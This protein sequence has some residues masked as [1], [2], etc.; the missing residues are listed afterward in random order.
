MQHSSPF[1]H[2]F[3]GLPFYKFICF[4]FPTL[5]NPA[6]FRL[7][8]FFSHDKSIT[9]STNDKSVDGVLG[10]QTWGSRMVGANDSIELWRHPHRSFF[11]GVID[12]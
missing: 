2:E 9:N 6:S 12:F 7:F 3:C 1:Q 4:L 11:N 5:P 8:S 10:T